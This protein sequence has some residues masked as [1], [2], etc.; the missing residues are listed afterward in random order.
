MAAILALLPALSV[1]AQKQF[2]YHQSVSRLDTP[3]SSSALGLSKTLVIEGG[4][5]M[6]VDSKTRWGLAVPTLNNDNVSAA[7]NNSIVVQA[8]IN[9]GAPC[10]ESWKF[11]VGVG[12]QHSQI[13]KKAPYSWVYGSENNINYVLVPLYFQLTKRRMTYDF[14]A[15][16]TYELSTISIGH[17][18]V[19]TVRASRFCGGPL[20]GVGYGFTVSQNLELRAGVRFTCGIM[21]YYSYS[22]QYS[23]PPEERHYDRYQVAP[24]LMLRISLRWKQ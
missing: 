21:R 9:V 22:E 7:Y 11:F 4:L 14:G 17:Y 6:S 20:I 2:D 12:F 8:D 5:A 16:V 1:G 23:T 18:P 15:N 19:G 24:D 13:I 10:G 3:A